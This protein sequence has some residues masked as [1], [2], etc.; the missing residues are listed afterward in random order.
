MKK[1]IYLFIVL[2]TLQSCS[3]DDSNPTDPVTVADNEPETTDTI[4][5]IIGTWKLTSD[6]VNGIEDANECN[7]NTTVTFSADGSYISDF[8]EQLNQNNC[9]ATQKLEGTWVN[10]G[11]SNYTLVFTDED[12]ELTEVFDFIFSENNTVFTITELDIYNGI[13]DTLTTTFTK[14]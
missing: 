4:D 12:G 7:K 5:P 8:Y 2:F 6:L 14:E 3:N 1:I 9:E 11:D 13:T 10:N